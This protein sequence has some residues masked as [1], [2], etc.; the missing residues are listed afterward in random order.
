MN[1]R[2]ACRS[3]L[4]S[5]PADRPTVYAGSLTI[6]W[7]QFS[8]MLIPR[9]KRYLLTGVL[10]VLPIGLTVL[11]FTWIWSQLAALGAPIVGALVRLLDPWAP[12][13]SA[14]LRDSVFTGAMGVGLVVAAVYCIGWIASNML[15]RRL[16]NWVDAVME[17]LPV[18]AQV[19][20]AIRKTLAALQTQPTSGQRVVLIPFPSADMLTV[21]LVTRV[22]RDSNSGR[23]V[24][25]VY[26]PTTPNPT[27]GYLEI[28]PLELVQDTG[29]SVDQAMTFIISGGTVGPD[30]L[31]FDRVPLPDTESKAN[32]DQETSKP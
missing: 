31:P 13:A 23:E 3:D 8:T 26:V 5:R 22:F 28:V 25:A 15:G 2:L 12:Q 9:F 32:A 4:A 7:M 21:G 19:H 29:W 20:G 24:A 30:E 27:S 1:H 10:T 16:L 11:L 18:V 6:H 17:R 14:L